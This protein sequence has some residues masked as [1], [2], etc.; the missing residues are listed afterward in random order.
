MTSFQK[1][2]TCSEG[3]KDVHG[4][5]AWNNIFL[6]SDSNAFYFVDNRLP[7]HVLRNL[8][9]HISRKPRQLITHI[10]RI[11]HC[12]Y[13]NLSEQLFAAL[14]D[15]LVVLDRRGTKISRR[16]IIGTRSKLSREQ[17]KSLQAFMVNEMDISA[18]AGNQYSIFTKG[19]IGTQDLVQQVASAST[20]QAYDPLNLARDYIEYSQ[21]AEARDVLEKAIVNEPHRLEL[22]QSLLELYKST[23]DV[24]GLKKMVDI[25][26]DL[27][28]AMPDDWNELMTL[29][30]SS[31]N[32]Q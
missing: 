22:H 4:S 17:Y 30:M 5:P 6:P 11:Y 12:Y 7:E 26:A 29:F 19:L 13:A 20:K 21:L 1:L 16:M 10:Q 31:S 2:I 3:Q 8:V 15:F 23:Q 9:F 25:F 27:N 28:I 24:S 18:L 14:V 32:E